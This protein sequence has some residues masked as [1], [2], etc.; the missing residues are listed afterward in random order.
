MRNWQRFG[1]ELSGKDYPTGS[2]SQSEIGLDDMV[3]TSKLLLK[4][5]N[6][7]IAKVDGTL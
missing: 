6:L 3:N 4:H 2:N 1:M 7:Q 5:R